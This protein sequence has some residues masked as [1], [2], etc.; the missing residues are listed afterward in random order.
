MGIPGADVNVTSGTGVRGSTGGMVPLVSLTIDAGGGVVAV[1]T[2]GPEQARS[3]GLDLIAAAT[4]AAADT[5][6]RI[7]AKRRGL[8][9]DTLVLDLRRLAAIPPDDV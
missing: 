9:G 6:L 2:M 4:H 1:A 7:E 5:A 8:D 3:I